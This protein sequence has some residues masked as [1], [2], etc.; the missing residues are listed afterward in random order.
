MGNG[1][2]NGT[3]LMSSRTFHEALQVMVRYM[4]GVAERYSDSR[5]LPVAIK[6]DGVVVMELAA[7]YGFRENIILPFARQDVTLY[8]DD[9]NLGHVRSTNCGSQFLEGLDDAVVILVDSVVQTGRTVKASM[10]GLI[11]YGRPKRVELVTIL[12][13]PGRELPIK[14]D[15]AYNEI[16]LPNNVYVQIL[17]DRFLARL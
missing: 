8:R 12:D 5:V 3:E 15:F 2:R 4:N 13:R 7:K 14:P 11:D 9:L 1:I 17:G 16:D 10:S 6:N